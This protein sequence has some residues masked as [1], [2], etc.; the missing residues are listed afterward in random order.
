M[1]NQ[2]LKTLSIIFCVL[3]C[4]SCYEEIV[5]N[6]LYDWEDESHSNEFEPNYD[7]VFNQTKVNRIDIVLTA[8]EFNEMQIDMNT[9]STTNEAIIN[10]KY[11]GCDFYFNG[12]QWYDVGIRYKG[13]KK[14]YAS[15]LNG[16]GKL[17]L[18]FNFDEFETQNSDLKKQ[19]FYGFQELSLEPNFNDNSLMREKIASDLYSQFGVPASKTAY[20]EIH[21]DKGDGNPVYFGLYTMTEDIAKTILN[22]TFLSNTGNCYKADG[23]GAKFD[24]AIFTLDSFE[25]VTNKENPIKDDVQLL[26]DVLNSSL[27]FSNFTEWKTNLESIFDVDGFLKYLAV[28]NTIQHWNTYGNKKENYYLYNDPKDNLLKWVVDNTNE[29]L[30]SSGEENPIYI[31]MLGVSKKWA[32][33]YNLIRVP[34]YDLIYKSYIRSFITSSFTQPKMDE[35]Y[36][37]NKELIT[38]FVEKESSNYTQVQG[39]FSAFETEVENLINHTS[40]RLLVAERYIR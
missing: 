36:A 34:E 24:N 31:S 26:N 32:L 19:R 14:S 6:G 17:P 12:K 27:R 2:L 25:N 35:L 3:L 37:K 21:V 9:L 5:T 23:D 11:F 28:N 16:N 10:P 4:T 20:Y 13:N 15:F 30:K 1:K 38:S 29:A 18:K 33:I 40:T 39:G 8:A 22:R 7:V